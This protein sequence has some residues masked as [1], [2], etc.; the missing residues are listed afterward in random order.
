MT[1]L[2]GKPTNTDKRNQLSQVNEF[3]SVTL[4]YPE[5]CHKKAHTVVIFNLSHLN[6]MEEH[7]F[8]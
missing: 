2:N 1:R 8:Q 7:S 4:L 6:K 3:F 5:I